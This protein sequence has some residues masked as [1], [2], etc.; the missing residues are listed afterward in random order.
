[1]FCLCGVYELLG[2]CVG[3][4]LSRCLGSRVGVCVLVL[5]CDG[6]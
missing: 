4:C 2:V 3:L 6:F 1:M 5:V